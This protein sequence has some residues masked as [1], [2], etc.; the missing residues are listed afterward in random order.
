[1]SFLDNFSIPA[2]YVSTR[3]I[4]TNQF[5]RRNV[6]M[7]KL[8]LTVYDRAKPSKNCVDLFWMKRPESDIPVFPSLLSLITGNFSLLI[9]NVLCSR[10]GN[11]GKRGF[12]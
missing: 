11:S 2:T 9:F 1:M 10:G 12:R 5:L 8:P 6:E 4:P 3:N 7:K